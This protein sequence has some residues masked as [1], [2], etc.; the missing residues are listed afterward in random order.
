VRRSLLLTPLAI[1]PDQRFL[2]YTGR[3]GSPVTVAP[4]E[5]ALAQFK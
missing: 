1:A 4:W 2:P 3:Q 5:H